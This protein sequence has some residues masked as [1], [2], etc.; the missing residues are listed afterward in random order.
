MQHAAGFTLW[1]TQCDATCIWC[2]Y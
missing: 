1:L 2:K